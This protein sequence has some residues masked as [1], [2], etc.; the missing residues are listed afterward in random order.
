[1]LCFFLTLKIIIHSHSFTVIILFITSHSYGCLT[2]THCRRFDA[3]SD[4]G[5]DSES[6]LLIRALTIILLLFFAVN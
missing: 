1:M 4:G 5:A 3:A 6:E 2:R